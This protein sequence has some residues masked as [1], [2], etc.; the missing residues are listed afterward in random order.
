M[1]T[2]LA[3]IP[4]AAIMAYKIEGNCVNYS[5]EQRRY[6]VQAN[7]FS[8][9]KDYNKAIELYQK[10]IEIDQTAY[11][12]AYSNMALLSAQTGKF[13]DAIFYMKKYLLLEP[14]ASDSRGAR[15]KIYEWEAELAKN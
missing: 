5:E 7:S 1:T 12:A 4:A 2:P 6:I 13:S 11:P 3:F 8:Q 9:K 14:E 15:D 10:A